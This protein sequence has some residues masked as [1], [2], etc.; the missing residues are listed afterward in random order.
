MTLFL[1]LRDGV[2]RTLYDLHCPYFSP[3]V[4]VKL[5][6]KE[7][8]HFVTLIEVGLYLTECN[9]RLIYANLQAWRW[10]HSQVID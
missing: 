8:E 3:E 6:E 2:E 7:E 10:S 1:S 5:N 9:L 4:M